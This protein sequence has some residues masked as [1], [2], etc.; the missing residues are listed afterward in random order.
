V[1]ITVLLFVHV[2]SLAFDLYCILD[3]REQ[4]NGTSIF[5]HDLYMLNASQ[6]D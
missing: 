4:K 6:H 2:P 1:R 5:L 3:K